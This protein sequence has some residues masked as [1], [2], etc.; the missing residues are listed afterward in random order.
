MLRA[1]K[2]RSL[3]KDLDSHIGYAE[4][5]M[6]W[7]FQAGRASRQQD[8]QVL[9]QRCGTNKEVWQLQHTLVP[10]TVRVNDLDHLERNQVEKWAKER[11]LGN[12][13]LY[14]S[15]LRKNVQ[16]TDRMFGEE[17]K[18]PGARR[19]TRLKGA[20]YQKSVVTSVKLERASKTRA[21]LFPLDTAPTRTVEIYLP[22]WIFF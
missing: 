19:T 16:K 12:A 15:L 9:N 22:H 4:F 5:E 2:R 13:H 20:E 18:D 8:I 3:K 14:G 21:G 7:K 17:Q 1:C 11:I 10:E 6:L